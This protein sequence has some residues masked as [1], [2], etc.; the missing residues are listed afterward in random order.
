MSELCRGAIDSSDGDTIHPSNL[1][2]AGKYV[3]HLQCLH[4]KC[5]SLPGF[6]LDPNYGGLLPPLAI[7]PPLAVKPSQR[8]SADHNHLRQLSQPGQSPGNVL[9]PAYSFSNTA[10]PLTT[11]SPTSG[12]SP[13]THAQARRPTGLSPTWY[14]TVGDGEDRTTGLQNVPQNGNA[15]NGHDTAELLAVSNQLMDQEFLDMD[16]VITLE[17]MDFALGIDLWNYA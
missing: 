17:D 12:I 3:L 1:D 7:P 8:R 16:R 14:T 5:S 15:H 10:V 13:R 6:R 2:L 11:Q 4:Q 9:G